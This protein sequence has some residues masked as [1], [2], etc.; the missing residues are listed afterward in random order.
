MLSHEAGFSSLVQTLRHHLSADGGDGG[1]RGG[2]GDGDVQR[3]QPLHDGLPQPWQIFSS[4]S[5][6]F[7]HHG[8]HGS[9]AIAVFASRLA[10]SHIVRRTCMRGTKGTEE[11]ASERVGK[12]RNVR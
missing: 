7:T 6:W 12:V 1:D 9:V 10:T 3:A 8:L 5:G 4:L 2:G 11:A